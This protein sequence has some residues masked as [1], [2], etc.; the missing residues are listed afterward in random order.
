MFNPISITVP[1]LN[2]DS[3]IT[4]IAV[5]IAL[6][7]SIGLFEWLLRRIYGDE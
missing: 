5:V 4:I 2:G 7:V 1:T 3:V 6:V